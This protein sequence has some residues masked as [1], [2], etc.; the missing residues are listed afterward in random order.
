MLKLPWQRKK[1]EKR[2]LFNAEVK[3]KRIEGLETL[4]ASRLA[5]LVIEKC[6]RIFSETGAR[7]AGSP[8]AARCAELLLES[9]GQVSDSAALEEE[10]ADCSS[11]WMVYSVLPVAALSM[12]VFCWT[13]FPSLALVLCILTCLFIWHSFLLCSGRDRGLLSRDIVN[14]SASIEPEEAVQD[15][16]IFTSHHD[17]APMFL[18]QGQSPVMALYLPTVHFI[19]LSVV[20]LCLFISEII[21]ALGISARNLIAKRT[22]TF[23]T[24]FAG[25][26]GIIG[27][28]LVLSL[29]NGFD[30]YMGSLEES[31]LSSMPLTINSM[32]LDI[33][34]DSLMNMEFEQGEGEQYPDTDYVTPYSPTGMMGLEGIS[35]G[36][37]VLTDE[38]M[39]YVL[40]IADE[41]PDL[42]NAVKYSYGV[43][44]PIMVTTDTGTEIYEN[45][46]N[47]M[48]DAMSSMGMST[49]PIGWQQLLWDN[50]MLSQFDV[51]AGGY[52]GTDAANSA[53]GTS[54]EDGENY[55]GN[56]AHSAVLVINSYNMIDNSILEA[57]GM[58]LEQDADGNYHSINFDEIIGTEITVVTNDN[59]Y[60][61][62]STVY[63]DDGDDDGFIQANVIDEDGN[64]K[65]EARAS[66]NKNIASYDEEENITV[67][68]VGV[69][70][71]KS[72][73]LTPLL[74]SGVAYTED[75]VQLFLDDSMESEIVS[76][77]K[78]FS[79][80][81][82]LQGDKFSFDFSDIVTILETI[83]MSEADVI[84]ELTDMLFDPDADFGDAESIVSSMIKDLTE[85]EKAEVRACKTF[86]ELLKTI[87]KQ[88]WSVEVPLLGAIKISE[89]TIRSLLSNP[90]ISGILDKAIAGMMEGISI[91]TSSILAL[92]DSAYENQLKALGG[93]DTPIGVYIYPT[94]FE[95]KDQICAYLDAWNNDN[96]GMAVSYMDNAGTISDLLAQVVDIVSYILIAFSAISLVV[97]S[98]MIAIITYVSVLERT[99]EIGVL[100]SIGARKLDVSNL[101]NA[102]TAI[103][104]A[105]AGILGVFL[106]WII[107]FPINAWIASLAPQAPA[108][109]AVLNPLHALLLVALSIVL[110]V[111][112]GLV[113]AIAAARKDP[114][115]ALRSAG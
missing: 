77:Q 83:G 11:F 78:A 112:S 75:L 7:E 58:E 62:P 54:Y 81:D 18:R 50:F 115:K 63:G 100:R 42:L 46:S 22:R 28:A 61:V 52:P 1:E 31:I 79:S 8:Q 99:T 71:A 33:D 59:F 87:E 82:V 6:G 72:T 84:K 53:L 34:I 101:F 35:F 23:L 10:K 98:V 88:G 57:L 19:L 16:V 74:Q 43:N 110:T 90:F 114:V 86:S 51:L 25:S 26:I 95:A 105:S 41:F 102:E 60:T 32:A 97:S 109:F 85:E 44:M 108:N 107:D 38:Y 94:S 15:T 111:L 45:T 96:P 4:K 20:S 93:S 70:R 5:S 92:I 49:N 39:D 3:A 80:Y 27:I 68:I 13:G 104:G 30:L 113:P 14:V 29:S 73:V 17:S 89:S 12:L 55:N 37:N 64:F 67:T 69:L 106:A 48:S 76:Y 91:S 36:L 66:K 103:I 21:T 2:E 24:A 40:E 65:P 9:F 47:M 56:K